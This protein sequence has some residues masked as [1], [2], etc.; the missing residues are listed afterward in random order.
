LADADSHNDLAQRALAV[1]LERLGDVRLQLG[2]TKAAL[3]AHRLSLD[4]FKR[5]ADAHPGSHLAMRDLSVA[6]SRLGDP[7][8]RLDDF[9]SAR[10]CYHEALNVYERLTRE[11]PRVLVWTDLATMEDAMGLC[12]Q[13]AFRFKEAVEWHQ[14]GLDLLTRLEKVGKFQ[15]RA[16]DASLV[17]TVRQ[18]LD[19]ARSAQGAIESLDFVLKQP[20]EVQPDLFYIRAVA[21]AQKGQ[22][23]EAAV[24]AERLTGTKAK[25]ADLY[26]AACGFAQC[27]A[28]VARG[29]TPE[30]LSSADRKLQEQYV[31]RAL[32]LLRQAVA[33]GYR[34]VVHMQHDKDLE[35]LHDSADYQLIIRQLKKK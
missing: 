7:Q 20:A 14:R 22:H 34:D 13:Q 3:E 31:T 27:V 15:G 29:K 6:F 18:N 16:A 2:D 23:V 8:L 30:Q 25:G 19:T 9:V 1:A 5:L 24:A 28:A 12:E 35:T 10:N 21:L 11:Q 26:N 17:R 33:A 4:L 32:K